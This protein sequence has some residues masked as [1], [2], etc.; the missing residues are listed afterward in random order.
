MRIY[1]AGPMTGYP[2]YNRKTFKSISGL[3]RDRGHE[4]INPAELPEPATPAWEEYL[5]VALT[6]MLTCDLVAVIP[7]WELSAGACLEVEVA[8]RLKIPCLDYTQVGM[9]GMWEI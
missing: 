6:Q 4:V 7:G 1:L 9:V 8:Q 2:D 5:K 3:L